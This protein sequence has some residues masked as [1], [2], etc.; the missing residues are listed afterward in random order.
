MSEIENTPSA[1]EEVE[2][3]PTDPAPQTIVE[4]QEK[5][6]APEP[7]NLEEAAGEVAAKQ[8]RSLD[9]LSLDEQSR[10]KV[11]SYISRQIND[12]RGKWETRK[13]QEIEDGKFMTRD[14]VQGLLQKQ[15][16]QTAAREQAKDSFVRN[17]S[18]LGI[19]IGSEEYDKVAS[20]YQEATERGMVNPQILSDPEGLQMLAKLAG[21]LPEAEP[22]TMQPSQG[23]PKTH[24]DGLE[25][26]DGSIQLGAVLA[27]GQEVPTQMRIEKAMIEA[28]RDSQ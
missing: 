9:E 22:D 2:A 7:V 18:K 20:Y 5:E 27:E 23:L 14:E 6:P 16:D 10:A 15:A 1:G 8:P 4:P 12:A 13:Q 21:A 3:T 28:M 26:S 11:E 19:G 25:H 17:L 24:P